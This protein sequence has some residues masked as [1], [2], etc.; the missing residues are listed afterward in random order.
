M[1]GLV[2]RALQSFLSDTYGGECWAHVARA[3]GVDPGGFEAM[4]TYDDALTEAVLDAA[5]A[6][7]ALPREMMLEDLGTYLVSH[8]DLEP[9]RRLLRFGGETFLDFLFS[10]DDLPER[11]RLAVPD[12]ELPELEVVEDAE[13]SI[14]IRCRGGWPGTAFILQGLVRAMADDYGALALLDVGEWAPDQATVCISL[15]DTAFHEGRSFSL[16]VDR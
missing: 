10:L 6:R 15:L 16:A 5:I 1:H 12:L 8:P 14:A 11:A 3:A 2:N 4:L 7:L 9:L 13:G